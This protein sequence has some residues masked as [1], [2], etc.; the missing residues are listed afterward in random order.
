M[1]RTVHIF[2][3]AHQA[4]RRHLWGNESL[5]SL[6][7]ALDVHMMPFYS[8]YKSYMSFSGSQDVFEGR[9]HPVL[10]IHR[11][12]MGHQ[13]CGSMLVSGILF[14]CCVGWFRA[15]PP[16]PPPCTPQALVPTSPRTH[17]NQINSFERDLKKCHFPQKWNLDDILPVKIVFLP[18]IE[19]VGMVHMNTFGRMDLEKWKQKMNVGR[20]LILINSPGS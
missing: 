4:L 18:K 7:S 11:P 19:M 12:R 2:S 5:I 10:W 13:A 3:G 20:K 1:D 17:P 15:P 6:R 16:A 14:R 9:C 8:K